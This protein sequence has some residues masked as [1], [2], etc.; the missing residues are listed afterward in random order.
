M[1]IGENLYA[2]ACAAID[3]MGR[4]VAGMEIPVD[5]KIPL[6]IWTIDN[7][8]E[9]GVPAE[10]SQGYGEAWRKGYAALWGLDDTALDNVS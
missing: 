3:T 2:D 5:T 1:T 4:M 10:Y 9:A 8:E 7:A 6:Y